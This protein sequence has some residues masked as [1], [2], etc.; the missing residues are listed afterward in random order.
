[1]RI[2]QKFFT[3]LLFTTFSV[4]L[5]QEIN[6]SDTIFITA[7]RIETN[8]NAI[9]ISSILITKSQI[10]EKSIGDVASAL[11]SEAGIDVRNYSLINGASSVSLFGST[12]QQV[13]VLLDGLPINSPSTGTPDL[14]LIPINIIDRIEIVKGPTSSLYGANGLGGVVN[15]VSESPLDMPKSPSYDIGLSYG[16]YQTSKLNFSIK[17]KIKN[18][19]FMSDCH[20][21]K[22]KGL[23]TNDD[24]LTQGAGFVSSYAFTHTNKLRLD[25][26]YESKELG[27][28]GPKPDTSQRPLYGDS[29]AFSRYDRQSDTSYLI[30]TLGGFRL[31]PNWDINFNSHYLMNNTNFLWVDAYRLDSLLLYRDR[32]NSKTILGNLISRY[33]FSEGRSLAMGCDYENDK[34][35][36]FTPDTNWSPSLSK[37]GIFSEGSVSFA[38]ILRAFGSLRFD[39]NSGF[40]TF[41]S[42]A[43]GLTNNI[44]Q[45]LKLRVHIGRAYRAP[46]LNDLYWPI[47]GNTNIKPEVGN[48]LQFGFDYNPT[49]YLFLSATAFARKTTN[50]I[51]WTPDSSGIWRPANIDTSTVSGVEWSSRFKIFNDLRF[52][53]VGTVQ[54][55]VQVKKEMVYYDW[56]TNITRFDYK[57]KI[58]A[59]TPK[60][61]LSTDL[62]YNSKFGTEISLLSKFTSTRINYYQ[63]YD[64]LPKLTIQEKKLRAHFI[65]S[66]HIMQKLHNAVHLKL[67]V[68]N[69]LNARYAEQFGNSIIDQDYPRI[70]RS[71]FVGLDFKN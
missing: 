60:F 22:T 58:Q 65:L 34:F 62:N 33:Q 10:K 5:A 46:T 36:A 11:S 21:L 32:Y 14:G 37:F 51:S 30:K 1:M 6:S 70:G 52:N 44:A 9:P 59:F 4:I 48:A 57:K 43:F 39:L 71:L 28:P 54:N 63:S 38:K 13:L 20:Q 8:I 68:E 64:S 50:L 45:S 16:S 12:S 47:S 27:V 42:P 66:I 29:T 69:V 25:F 19:Y 67:Q 3:C 24:V 7:T 56:L 55:A 35:S 40:G 18:Y 23:R 49:S 31:T 41:I 61:C 15:F 2:K 53:F 26:R 17:D